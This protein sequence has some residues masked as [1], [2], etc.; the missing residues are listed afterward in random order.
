MSDEDKKAKIKKYLLIIGDEIPKI[1]KWERKP[2]G[3]SLERHLWKYA[4]HFTTMDGESLK[5]LYVRLDQKR[6]E[7]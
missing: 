7:G 2:P 6:R 1:L 3:S 4:S 5:N